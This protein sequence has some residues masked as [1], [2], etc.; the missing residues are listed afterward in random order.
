MTKITI[1]YRRED[2]EAIT[3][4]IFDRLSAIYGRDSLF[5][6]IDSIPPGIDFRDHIDNALHA[7]NVVV[8][9]IGPRW[10][11]RAKGGHSRISEEADFVRIEVETALK[12]GIPV[13]PVLIGTT[14]MPLPE[15]LPDCLREVAFRNA[16]RVDTGQDFDLHMTRFIHNLNQIIEGRTAEA[17]TNKV[18]TRRS[19]VAEILGAVRVEPRKPSRKVMLVGVGLLV[20]LVIAGIGSR[21]VMQRAALTQLQA[22]PGEQMRLGLRFGASPDEIFGGHGDYA[23]L[24]IAA[25]YRKDEVRYTLRY[26]DKNEQ[27]K[28]FLAPN[29]CM[30]SGSYVVWLFEDAKL[31]R[32]SVRLSN[33]CSY[34]SAI[35]LLK[36]IK[37]P[38]GVKTSEHEDMDWTVFEFIKP[39]IANSDGDIWPP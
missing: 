15:Q 28:L 38:P 10:L 18:A 23:A 9:I 20:F 5:R 24:P 36:S 1:S 35:D 37:L 19:A 12:L 25:E 39:G 22:S 13:I 33:G 21:F 8:I 7:S 2:S 31:F 30:S 16:V 27:W 34:S 32:V 14:R 26:I 17:H 4:R 11:G 6:D 3:G 29:N